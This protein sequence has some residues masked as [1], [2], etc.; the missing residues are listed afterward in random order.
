MVT[1][2]II[3]AAS[4][5]YLEQKV[6]AKLNAGWKLHDTIIKDGENFYQ[7]MTLTHTKTK[8]PKE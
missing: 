3:E 2:K 7:A 5:R 8:K 4:L 1:F 6:N